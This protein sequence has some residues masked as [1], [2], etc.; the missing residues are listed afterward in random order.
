MATLLFS[1]TGL[2][3]KRQNYLPKID[4]NEASS[5]SSSM[6]PQPAKQAGEMKP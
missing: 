1:A 2:R 6:D 3:K 4:K 5:S